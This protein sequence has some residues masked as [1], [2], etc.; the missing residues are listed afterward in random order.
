MEVDI[1]SFRV[2]DW[3]EEIDESSAEEDLSDEKFLS[4]H[5]KTLKEL[6]AKWAA[7]LEDRKRQKQEAREKAKIARINSKSPRSR[8]ES[9]PS[10][11]EV[12]KLQT[13]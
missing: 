6:N 5:E 8:R 11:K 12:S 4:L 1:P 9:V 2:H 10:E 3:T 13:V 7:A